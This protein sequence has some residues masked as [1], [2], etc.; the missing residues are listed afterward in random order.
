MSSAVHYQ[1]MEGADHVTCKAVANKS[2]I[3]MEKL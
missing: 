3:T 1:Q 2:L